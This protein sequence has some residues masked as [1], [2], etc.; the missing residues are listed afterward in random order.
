MKRDYNTPRAERLNFDYTKVV[1]ASG[2]P[3]DP[4]DWGNGDWGNGNGCG[5]AVTYHGRSHGC[6]PKKH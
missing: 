1:V 6:N 2:N 4:G 5:R 3:D